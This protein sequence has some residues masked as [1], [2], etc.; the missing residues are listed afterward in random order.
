[1]TKI[2]QTPE[3]QG[4]F[5]PKHS[6]ELSYAGSD[7]A[8]DWQ[9]FLEFVQKTE[10]DGDDARESSEVRVD[11][12]MSYQEM[13]ERQRKVLEIEQRPGQ[14]LLVTIMDADDRR[15]LVFG[16]DMMMV[17]SMSD[18]SQLIEEY[19]KSHTG[20]EET[21]LPTLYDNV[22]RAIIKSCQQELNLLQ[23]MTQECLQQMESM[24]TMLLTSEAKMLK[25]IDD[26][27]RSKFMF[28]VASSKDRRGSVTADVAQAYSSGVGSDVG[29]TG[30]TPGAL[31]AK[32]CQLQ[33][34]YEQRELELKHYQKVAFRRR[35]SQALL[36]GAPLQ[37]IEATIAER[38]EW[39][40]EV[41][42]RIALIKVSNAERTALV[43]DN[44]TL[45]TTVECGRKTGMLQK[46]RDKIESERKQR[47][48][49]MSDIEN[50]ISEIEAELRIGEAEIEELDMDSSDE[51]DDDEGHYE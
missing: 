6:E 11:D 7:M 19:L 42:S 16:D 38:E 2:F 9:E 26:N 36:A 4:V 20:I 45:R 28:D 49:D 33:K 47:L 8:I 35:A 46:L 13:V 25:G 44:N 12:P 50:E 39:R 23:A 32:V 41:D 10:N 43:R 30:Q 27:K 5:T 17:D 14:E 48:M 34:R 22:E 40:K 24:A 15:A 51:D 31:A 29:G 37:D 1:M 3:L 21:S 18:T